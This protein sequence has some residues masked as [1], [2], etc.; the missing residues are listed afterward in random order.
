VRETETHVPLLVQAVRVGTRF[1][2]VDDRGGLC[3]WRDLRE[4]PPRCGDHAL[5]RGW[6]VVPVATRDAGE[7]GKKG[8]DGA[9]T[10]DSS[11]MP[12]PREGC[13]AAR[14]SRPRG[15]HFVVMRSSSRNE[16]RISTSTAP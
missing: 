11:T 5:V 2:S 16:G 8:R 6:E 13:R 15:V 7:E 10:H 12:R 1:S 3:W 9:S 14:H 4:S